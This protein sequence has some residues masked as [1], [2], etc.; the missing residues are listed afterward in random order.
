[1]KVSGDRYLLPRDSIVEFPPP[2]ITAPGSVAAKNAM[3]SVLVSFLVIRSGATARALGPDD[4]PLL[5]KD[6][7]YYQ[8]LTMEIRTTAKALEVIGRAVKPKDEVVAYMEDV[9]DSKER[10][11]V[12]YLH[13]R[14][15]R[16][17]AFAEANDGAATE[18]GTEQKKNALETPVGRKRGRPPGSALTGVKNPSAVT[19][20]KI[21]DEESEEEELKDSYEMPSSLVPMAWIR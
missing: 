19:V 13:Y 14:L 2:K 10:V 3:D 16:A 21:E 1:M 18:S 6:K 15:P 17:D 12:S 9:F 8:P 7:E 4:Q 5:D 11:P 20:T